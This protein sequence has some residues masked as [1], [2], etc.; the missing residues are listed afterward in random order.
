MIHYIVHG[1]TDTVGVMT[2]DVKK[3]Q[4]VTGWNM[5]TDKTLRAKAVQSIPLGHKI[6]VVDVPKGETI[7]KYD[8]AIGRASRAIRRGEH[9]HVHNV[10]SAVQ[11]GAK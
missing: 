11:G 4:A 1:K 3:G 2:V 8:E 7:V 9:V 10:E 6:A 5:A